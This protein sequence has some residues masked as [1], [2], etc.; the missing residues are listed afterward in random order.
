MP[1]TF[2]WPAWLNIKGNVINW[3]KYYILAFC[4]C[5]TKSVYNLCGGMIGQ[6]T[7]PSAGGIWSAFVYA[8]SLSPA[9][10]MHFQTCL[11]W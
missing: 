5:L 7:I 2:N 10:N 1:S 8:A 3:L 4:R 9:F 11:C 6:N